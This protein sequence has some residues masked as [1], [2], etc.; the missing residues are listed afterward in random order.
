V[1]RPAQR[2]TGAISG[3]VVDENG[4]AVYGVTYYPGV[5]SRAQAQPVFVGNGAEQTI[6]IELVRQQPSTRWNV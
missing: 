5:A 2:G 3:T 6:F 4:A 1:F